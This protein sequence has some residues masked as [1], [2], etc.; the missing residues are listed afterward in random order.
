MLLFMAVGFLFAQQPKVSFHKAK[1]LPGAN[2]YIFVWECQDY[3][4]GYYQVKEVLEQAPQVQ[5]QIFLWKL[6]QIS[7]IISEEWGKEDIISLF[8]GN[9]FTIREK[10]REFPSGDANH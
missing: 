1:T 5:K 8:S 10:E 3:K 2:E 7:A 6:H 9:G 4:A